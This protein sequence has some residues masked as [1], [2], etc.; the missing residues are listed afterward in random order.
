MLDKKSEGGG[1]YVIFVVAI[2]PPV[3]CGLD[4]QTVCLARASTLDTST[5]RSKASPY[6]RNILY[7]AVDGNHGALPSGRKLQ[8]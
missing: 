8:P 1:T 5:Y 3:G 4:A 2:A 6:P 7:R